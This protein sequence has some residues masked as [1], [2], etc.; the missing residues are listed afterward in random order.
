MSQTGWA[1]LAREAA[2][3]FGLGLYP[4]SSLVVTTDFA[5]GLVRF[6]LGKRLP[7]PTP[8]CGTVLA[9]LMPRL[10]PCDEGVRKL[11]MREARQSTLA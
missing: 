9:A 5:Y 11:E 7:E 1:L 2:A 10:A 4:P 6:D 3:S 8:D